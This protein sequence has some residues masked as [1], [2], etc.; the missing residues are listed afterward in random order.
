ME[1]KELNC[2]RV[3]IAQSSVNRIVKKDLRLVCFKKRKAH[4]L[5]DAK[6]QARLDRA[7][8]LLDRY[9][10]GMENLM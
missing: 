10:P 3:D 1:H 6:K 2:K 4:D 7:H 9:P 8:Q 5:T